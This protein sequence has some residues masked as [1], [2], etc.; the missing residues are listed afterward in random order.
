MYRKVSLFAAKRGF[1]MLGLL[2]EKSTVQITLGGGKDRIEKLMS[3]NHTNHV[4]Q[5]LISLNLFN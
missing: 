4:Q 2:F 1:G 3:T 5:P